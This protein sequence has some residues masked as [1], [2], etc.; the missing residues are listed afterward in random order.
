MARP[1]APSCLPHPH[2][3]LQCQPFCQQ[4]CWGMQ[5]VLFQE[6]RCS[7][8]WWTTGVTLC[9]SGQ[10]ALGT[11]TSKEVW[12]EDA[13]SLLICLSVLPACETPL[14]IQDR[15]SPELGPAAKD[16]GSLGHTCGLG[17]HFPTCSSG[18]SMQMCTC[19]SRGDAPVSRWI[20]RTW[21]KA[22]LESTSP[23]LGELGHGTPHC[24][25]LC[26]ISPSSW[27]LLRSVCR[28]SDF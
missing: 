17:T 20:S 12:D 15:G 5:E 24:K 25:S 14:G 1:A 22:G 4:L 7:R 13:F 28:W 8:G 11:T 18:V 16:M 2:W 3:V 27:S 23:I 10:M 19:T 26:V 21:P 6:T 9:Q